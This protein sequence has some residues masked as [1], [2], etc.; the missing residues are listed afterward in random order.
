[1]KTILFTHTDLDGIGAGI[2]GRIAFDD[3]EIE[4]HSYNSI[5]DR[6]KEFLDS[7]EFR[8]YDNIYITDIS[9]NNELASRLNDIYE[10]TEQVV[11]LFD[12]HATAQELNKYPC[13]EVQLSEIDTDDVEIPVCGTSLFYKHLKF[14][15]E[16]NE[17]HALKKFVKLVQSYDTW[18]WTKTNNIKAK[19]LNDLLYIYG[20]EK[21]IDKICYRCENDEDILTIGDMQFLNIYYRQQEEY[22]DKKEEQ[23]I[24]LQRDGYTVGI[25]FAEQHISMLGNTLCERHPEIDYALI[26][27]NNCVSLRSTKDVNVGEIARKHYNG[28]GHLHAAGYT[29]PNEDIQKFLNSVLYY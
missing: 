1:M 21:F 28:G 24:I 15:G 10:S 22:I 16:I 19:N 23:M 4:Y 18:M 7:E 26:I 17:N 5:N 20:K 8:I 9:V 14:I 29:I 6:I 27:N 13:C 25:V 12:H 11:K 3:I 2:L